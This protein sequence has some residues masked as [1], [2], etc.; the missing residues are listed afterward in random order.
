MQKLKGHVLQIFDKYSCCIA[1][2]FSDEFFDFLVLLCSSQKKEPVGNDDNVPE[3]AKNLDELTADILAVSY[4]FTA[5]CFLI[6]VIYS[7]IC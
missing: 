2:S 3:N 7:F 1:L 5:F 4:F 6:M